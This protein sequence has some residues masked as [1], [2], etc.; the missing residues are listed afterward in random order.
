MFGT[1]GSNI[2]DM[3]IM[4]GKVNAGQL[5]TNSSVD[6]ISGMAGA[7]DGIAALENRT[8][9]GKI[10]V[11]P[12]LHDLNLISLA[13]LGDRFPSVAAKLDDGQW[14]RQAEEELLRVA[15]GDRETA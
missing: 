14:C 9:A 12:M 1:S 10:V 15:T 5:D 6:A 8:M 13:Q 2:Q 7:I 4:L 3:K 11:Y